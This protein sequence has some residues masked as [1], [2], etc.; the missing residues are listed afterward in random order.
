MK[1]RKPLVINHIIWWAV[2]LKFVRLIAF[3]E[4]KRT[5]SSSVTEDEDM[6]KKADNIERDRKK[7]LTSE[8]KAE[9]GRITTAVILAYCRACTWYMTI[10]VLLFNVLSNALAVVT[11]FWLADWSNAAGNT[12]AAEVN[13]TT[14]IGRVTACD[15]AG[16]VEW[17]FD[18]NIM[19][20]YHSLS[21]SLSLSYTHL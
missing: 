10:F 14:S 7:S 9:T 3:L 1:L 17:V 12:Q 5:G 16:F 21:L 4:R 15:D 8:E 18:I 11:N 20:R 19:L 13:V 6:V 2:C